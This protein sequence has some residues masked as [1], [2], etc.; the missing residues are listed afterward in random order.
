MPTHT[1]RQSSCADSRTFR[2]RVP[3]QCTLLRRARAHSSPR[4]RLP[5]ITPSIT[6][7][8]SHRQR[9]ISGW[10]GLRTCVAACADESG[11]GVECNGPARNHRSWGCCI[12]GWEPEHRQASRFGG[13][14]GRGPHGR[15][16]DFIAIPQEL[17]VVDFLCSACGDVPRRCWCSRCDRVSAERRKNRQ[18]ADADMFTSAY[19]T[20]SCCCD[21]S[22][23]GFR[24]RDGEEAA[25]DEGGEDVSLWRS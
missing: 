6:T 22:R 13:D 15:P 17:V 7:K 9:S 4:K 1:V 19:Q 3:L 8:A 18:K 23:S 24:R 11:N 20:P 14:Q 5:R 10:L 16:A 25:G 2:H 12:S 21:G